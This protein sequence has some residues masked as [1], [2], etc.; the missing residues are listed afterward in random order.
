[1]NHTLFKHD[2]HLNPN[3]YISSCKPTASLMQMQLFRI[4][5][6]HSQSSFLFFIL[7]F[8]ELFKT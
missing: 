5:V 3:I 4:K 1:M 8:Y 2:T 6:C 7:L